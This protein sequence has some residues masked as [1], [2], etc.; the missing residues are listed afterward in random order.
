MLEIERRRFAL[1]RKSS[2]EV[3]DRMKGA[4]TLYH[5]WL[6]KR[7]SVNRHNQRAARASPISGRREKI[8]LI[9]IGGRFA[10]YEQLQNLNLAAA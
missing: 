3:T 6:I 9:F 7:R 5:Q 4:A 10:F 2:G 1:Q 8:F